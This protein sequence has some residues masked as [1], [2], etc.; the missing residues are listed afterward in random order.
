MLPSTWSEGEI[1]VRAVEVAQTPA[2]HAAF[3]ECVDVVGLDPTFAEVPESTVGELVEQSVAEEAQERGFR[4]RS[5]HVGPD[6]ELAGY[7]HLMEDVPNADD[8]WLSILAIR[9]RFR[10]SGVGTTLIGSLKRVL[11]AEGFRFALARVYLANVPALQFWTRLGF[12]DIVPHRG[13]YV[14]QDLGKAC[15]VLRASLGGAL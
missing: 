10:R 3:L 8:A 13:D 2:L 9:S 12:I 4:M 7:F 1:V 5:I 6:E 11:S 14:G 15:I